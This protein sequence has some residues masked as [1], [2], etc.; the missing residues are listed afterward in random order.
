MPKEFS[1]T[2]RVSELIQRELAYLIQRELGDSH[3]G[4]ITISTVEMSVDLK[5]A[6]VYITVLG[7]NATIEQTVQSLNDAAKLLRHHLSQR[8]TLRTTPRLQF[9]YDSSLE[10]GNRLLALIDSIKSDDPHS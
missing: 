4:L 9:I 2:Q 8:L 1:R 3:L 7:S 10:Q 6:R 5:A